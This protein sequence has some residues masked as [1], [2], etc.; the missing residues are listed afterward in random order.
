MHDLSPS[1][2]KILAKRTEKMKHVRIPTDKATLNSWQTASVARNNP[3]D[4][5]ML[6]PVQKGTVNLQMKS[7]SEDSGKKRKAGL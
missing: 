2:Y 7:I 3:C 6:Q 4:S 5:R 1:A